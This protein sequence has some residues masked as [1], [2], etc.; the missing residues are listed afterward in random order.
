MKQPRVGRA[1]GMGLAA[2]VLAGA[3]S[4][5]GGDTTTP[6]TPTTV[7]DTF[8]GTLQALGSVQYP[9]TVNSAGVVS[10]TVTSLN[11]QATI[12]VGFG[13]GQP[14]AG[15]CNLISGAFSESAKVGQ[16]ISGTINAGSYCVVLY[17]IGNVVGSDDFVIQISHS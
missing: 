13:L 7:I 1:W 2:L 3:L 9:F 5:C 10:A 4:A 16:P 8:N 11:P 14:S 17:D 15:V 6:T 12:T